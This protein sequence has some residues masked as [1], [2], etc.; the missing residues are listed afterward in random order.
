M[1]FQLVAS[2]F[3]TPHSIATSSNGGKMPLAVSSSG[4]AR[5]WKL[6]KLQTGLARVGE[7]Q[8]GLGY[9]GYTSCFFGH[10]PHES[11][12]FRP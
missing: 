2:K 6:W 7:P 3:G 12:R 10:T 8:W 5:T 9:L 4:I 1:G 11:L